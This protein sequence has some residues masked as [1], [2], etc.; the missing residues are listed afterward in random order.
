MTVVHRFLCCGKQCTIYVQGMMC[1]NIS[2]SSSCNENEDATEPLEVADGVETSDTA[3][4]EFANRLSE[5]MLSKNFP[6]FPF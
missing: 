5:Q 1:G 3:S 4:N 2:M 6:R